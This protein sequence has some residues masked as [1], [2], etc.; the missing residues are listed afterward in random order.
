MKKKVFAVVVLSLFVS[1]L[2]FAQKTNID[3]DRSANFS[4]FHTYMW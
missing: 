3:W 2:A 4:N 1:T